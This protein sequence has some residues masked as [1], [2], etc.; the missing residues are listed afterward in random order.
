MN[1]YTVL[2]LGDKTQFEQEQS[3]IDKL[4]S[5]GYK[6][7]REIES[8]SIAGARYKYENNSDNCQN[9]TI[10]ELK[11]PAGYLKTTST[12]FFVFSIIGCLVL[13]FL[14]FE[15]SDSYGTRYFAVIYFVS[16]IASFLVAILVH[17]ICKVLIFIAN[18]EKLR[19]D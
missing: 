9:L 11:N 19:Q 16:A 6:I 4:V 2:R 15:A 18:N 13:V 8:N 7:V 12:L 3:A 1:R 5:S 14:G 17:S 10:P